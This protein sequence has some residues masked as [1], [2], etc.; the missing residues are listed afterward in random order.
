ME[1]GWPRSKRKPPRAPSSKKTD[2]SGASALP[3]FQSVPYDLAGEAVG[4]L[5]VDQVVF[6]FIAPRALSLTALTQ[7]TTASAVIKIQKNGSDVTLPGAVSVAAADLITAKVTT[8][9]TDVWF[10]VTGVVA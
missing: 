9:G 4:A 3:S 6:H 5:T 7:G 1:I 2:S 10:T 8:A